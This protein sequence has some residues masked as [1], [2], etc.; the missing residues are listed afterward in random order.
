MSHAA[1]QPAVEALAN[2]A[3]SFAPGLLT[4]RT[5]LISGGGS[6]IG[7]ATAW[8]AARLG[9][10]V[11]VAGR[12]ADKLDAVCAAMAAHSLSC[13]AEPVDIRQRASVETVFDRIAQRHGPIDILINSAGGQFPQ[14]AID[15]SPKGWHAVVETNLYGT[16]HMMQCAAQ[17]WRA[18]DR[19]GSIVS[20][21]VSPRGLHHVAHSSAARAGVVAFTQAVAVEWAPLGI[22]AN[23]V[24]PGAIRSEGWKV[25][26]E[27]VSQ[28]YRDSNPMRSV[29]EPWDIAEACIY[30]ASPSGR[31]VTGEVLEVNGGGHLWGEVWTTDKP[32]YFL[33]A[34]RSLEPDPDPV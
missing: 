13:A 26:P 25:Y 22:R 18:E 14:P 19:G 20:I 32:P 4:G 12:K 15:I 21:V 30:L 34:S 17:R 27:Q 5:A 28:R 33:E 10:R 6:G 8:L 7:E 9:A 3:T 11:I 16:F 1:S 24:A 29:G 23:C 31:F 2:R